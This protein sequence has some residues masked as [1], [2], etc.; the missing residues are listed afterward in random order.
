[1]F[2]VYPLRT[3]VLILNPSVGEI[4]EISSPASFLSIVVFPALSR[5]LEKSAGRPVQLLLSQGRDRIGAMCASR[6]QEEHPHLFRLCL[7]LSDDSEKTYLG[8]G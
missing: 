5:P 2:R 3:S 1:M 8:K 4:W 6:L 7:V